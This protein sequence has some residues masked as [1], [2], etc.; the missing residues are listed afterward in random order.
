MLQQHR[1]DLEY[2]SAADRSRHRSRSSRKDSG[3][4]RATIALRHADP[5]ELSPAEMLRYR[6]VRSRSRSYDSVSPRRHSR[7]PSLSRGKKKKSHKKRK[8]SSTSSSSRRRSSSSSRE[9]SKHRHIYKKKKKHTNSHSSKRD[10]HVK[11]HKRKR[12]PSLSSSSSSIVSSSYSSSS[13]Q[14]SPAR[15]RSRSRSRSSSSAEESF[16]VPAPRAVS[17]SLL[18]DGISLCA[19]D[20]D[21]FNSH[22]EEHQDLTP[23][24]EIRSNASDIH[25]NMSSEDMKF[26]NLIEEVFKL[27]PADRFPRK[28]ESVLGG[29]KPRSSIEMELMKAPRKSISLPQTKGPLSKALDCIKQ[30][31]GSVEQKDGSYPMPSTVAQDWLPSKSD[32]NKLVKLKYYQSHEELIPTATASALDPDA[33]RLDISLSGSYPVKVS[34][35][36]SL[37]GQ[38]RDMIRIL[39]HAEIFSFAA[40]KSLQSENMDSKVLLEILKS[41]SMA[42]TD[43]MSIATAQTLGLQQMRREAAI[44][45]APKG[46]LTTEAKRKLRLTPLTSKL[47]FGGQISDIYKENVT[48]NQ[49]RLV[50]KA[51]NYQAKPNPPAVSSR[52]PKA[53]SG[54]NKPKTQ[55]T[56]KK[57]FPFVPPSGRNAPRGSGSRGRGAGPS[58]RGASAS[59]KH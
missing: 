12:S 7:S 19:D 53:K 39:S 26:Q 9:R 22:S 43:A 55:E 42:V 24:T 27:L 56:P 59:G 49:E 23:D 40:F 46:S 6:R 3:T 58:R 50:K 34:S 28:T 54:K 5:G 4:H 48:E 29:N 17:P 45:S 44:E 31:M 8:H 1:L 11:K 18:R 36:Q 20:D 51:V 41:M 2:R 16:H 52:K 14:R 38:S 57:D 10:K 32:I 33:N 13:R 37:E 21:Q 15:K 30:S 25:S 35:L 47:L